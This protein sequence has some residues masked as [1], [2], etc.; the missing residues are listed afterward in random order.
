MNIKTTADKYWFVMNHPAFIN[1]R[2][3]SP[4]IEIEPQN[5]CPLTNRIEPYDYLNTKVQYWIEFLS[6]MDMQDG[7][8]ELAHD[9]MH[10]CGGDTIEEAIDELYNSVLKEYG[11]YTQEDLEAKEEE[12]YNYKGRTHSHS[13][14]DI[15]DKI[16]EENFEYKDDRLIS[17]ND[18]EVFR[19]NTFEHFENK[20]KEY[21]NQYNA[22]IEFKKN[23]P[24]EM[25]KEIDKDIKIVEHNI[26]VYQKS[27]EFKVD[28]DL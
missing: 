3:I 11:N 28:L 14:I 26:F 13:L 4:K 6:P 9:Y 27:I 7:T 1:K 19:S 2:Y 5:V 17:E 8:W 15:L 16:H 24:Q 23:A 18:A 10:D 21:Q 22:L 12:I 25:H 20:I